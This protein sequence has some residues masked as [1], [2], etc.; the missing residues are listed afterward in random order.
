MTDESRAVSQCLVSGHLPV[1]TMPNWTV[2][3]T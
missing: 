2:E 1:L 3:T